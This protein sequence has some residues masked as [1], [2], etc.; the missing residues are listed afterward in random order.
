MIDRPTCVSECTSPLLPRRLLDLIMA[1]RHSAGLLRADHVVLRRA[2]ASNSDRMVRDLTDVRCRVAVWN[3]YTRWF[4]K[5]DLSGPRY[6]LSFLS[7]RFALTDPRCNQT[8]EIFGRAAGNAASEGAQN[9]MLRISSYGMWRDSLSVK[10]YLTSNVICLLSP[11]RSRTIHI[12]TNK[13]CCL[14]CC[15]S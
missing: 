10:C 12:T 9:N 2:Q 7:D 5:R 8:R 13:I 4:L 3:Y 1:L 11:E 14:L 15:I 6:L